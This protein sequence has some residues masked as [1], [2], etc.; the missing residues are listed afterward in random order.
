MSGLSPKGGHF[1]PVF[2]F[3][4]FLPKK[5][6]S[7]KLTVR[8]GKFTILMVFTRKISGFSMA[9]V[10]NRKTTSSTFS[11][12]RQFFSSLGCRAPKK[13]VTLDHEDI[14]LICRASLHVSNLGSWFWFFGDDPKKH[15]ERIHGFLVGNLLIG[16]IGF[17]C[18]CISSS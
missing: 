1:H 10:F 18:I 11:S 3:S 5:L 16:F 9:F 13:T 12:R 8:R 14:S 2:Q 7:L 4:G 17:I 15:R 6:P